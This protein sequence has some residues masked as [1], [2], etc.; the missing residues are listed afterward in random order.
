MAQASNLMISSRDL[1]KEIAMPEASSMQASNLMISYID[2]IEEMAPKASGGSTIKFDY[3]LK[4]S[5]EAKVCINELCA[6]MHCVILI[7]K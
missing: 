4:R 7:I 1:I 5:Y 2:L 3:F 6:L